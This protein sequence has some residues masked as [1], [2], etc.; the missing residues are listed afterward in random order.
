MFEVHVNCLKAFQFTIFLTGCFSPSTLLQGDKL[1]RRNEWMRWLP[2]AH[3]QSDSG[4][5]SRGGSSC[6][7][8][9]DDFEKITLD[10]ATTDKVNSNPT[11]IGGATGESSNQS[12]LPSGDSTWSSN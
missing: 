9:A 11:T 1:R 8:I 4:S 2:S 10:E 7:S 6:N 12:Q 3:R 5:I